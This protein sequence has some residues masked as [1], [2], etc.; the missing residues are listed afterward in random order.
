MSVTIKTSNGWNVQH[1]DIY[2][3]LGLSITKHLP[4]DGL[5]LRDVQGVP[6][7]VLPKEM[8]E[9]QAKQ[10]GKAFVHRVFAV[11]TCGQHVPVG[12]LGQHKCHA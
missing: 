10:Q 5:P 3:L 12:R 11:C 1:N 8:A 6:V 7:Y 4:R 9:Y 2:R